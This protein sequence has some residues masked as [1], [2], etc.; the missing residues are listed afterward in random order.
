MTDDHQDSQLADM[1]L[2]A[3]AKGQQLACATMPALADLDQAMRV[4]ALIAHGLSAD[5]IGWKVAMPGS[6]AVAAPL[7][8]VVVAK[9]GMATE[10]PWADRL[11]VEVELAL[12]LSRDIPKTIDRLWT[13]AEL[14]DFVEGV[15]LGIEPVGGRL[16]EGSNAP[17]PLY[18]ADS[19][20]NAGYIV[21]ECLP[22]DVID[23][24]ASGEVSIRM[25]GSASWDG[26]AAHAHADPLHFLISY[27]NAQIDHLG[28]LKAG[29]IVTIGSLCGGV[30]VTAP[31]PIRIEFDHRF[32]LDLMVMAR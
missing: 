31:G 26:P 15:Y 7:F 27:A 32:G 12:K 14:L 17:F 20:D 28:G 16:K 23:R 25:S 5:V 9:T 3:R 13:R 2:A 22:P 19:L 4:Q 24:V 30:P 6:I 8:P 1:L 29:Q 21:G 18:L 10:I 11:G